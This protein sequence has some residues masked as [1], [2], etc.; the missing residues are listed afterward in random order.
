MR[1]PHL[2]GLAGWFL[3]A[4]CAAQ[5]R[6]KSALEYLAFSR[7]ALDAGNPGR[8]RYL[9]EDIDPKS[10]AERDRPRYKVLLAEAYVHLELYGDA[11]EVL[12]D[13]SRSFPTSEYRERA[14]ALQYEAGRR[15]AASGWTFLG[16]VSD[17][18]QARRVLEHFLTA[19]PRSKFLPDVLRILGEAAYVSEDYELAIDRYSQLAQ[20]SPGGAWA[21]LAAFRI[22][23]SHYRRL[24][25]PDYDAAAMERTRKELAGY[26]A[27]DTTNEAH[28]AQARQAL[29]QVLLWREQKDLRIAR[30]YI[31]IAKPVGARLQLERILSQPDA[32]L[33]DQAAELMRQ[34]EALERADRA[35]GESGR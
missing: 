24:E 33:R 10:F 25:G 18:D 3:L 31:T 12:R 11:F 20:K 13:F 7:A 27:T 21:D 32:R 2:S 1:A 15:L 16:L 29:A 35:A 28:L 9:L 22:A 26:L 23:M 4:S 14:E 8:A 34:V 19:Y 6:P 30:F 17:L 5:P